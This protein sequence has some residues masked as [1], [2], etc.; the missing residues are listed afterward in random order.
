MSMRPDSVVIHDPRTYD[1]GQTERENSKE[2]YRLNAN[3]MRD[4]RRGTK[5]MLVYEDINFTGN[6]SRS[7]VETYD[8]PF[9]TLGFMSP[10]ARFVEF[11]LPPGRKVNF[12]ALH[13]WVMY[14]LGIT[15]YEESRLVTAKIYQ[16]IRS[17][18]IAPTRFFKRAI[19]SVIAAR[20][21]GRL[22]RQPRK[23][24]RVSR[25][26]RLF[27]KLHRI[28]RAAR[29]VSRYINRTKRELG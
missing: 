24:R 18:G 10:Y 12:D 28:A 21:I 5:K 16:K 2:I 9:R 25:L 14:K 15:D 13:N 4:V 19:K 17:K 29:R 7:L 8:G 6:L 3:I 1:R 20:G 26:K 11:G 22:R 27:K 23:K